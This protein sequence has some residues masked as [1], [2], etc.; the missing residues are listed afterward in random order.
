MNGQGFGGG[1]L[2]KRY[3]LEDIGL[4][5]QIMLLV[6]RIFKK[7]VERS[8]SGMIWLKIGTSG[9]LL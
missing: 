8:W 2:R 1:N 3:L 7:S 9:G 4:D 6:E 5:V